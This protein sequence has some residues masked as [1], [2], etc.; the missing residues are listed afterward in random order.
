MDSSSLQAVVGANCRRIREA[1]GVTQAQ[2]ASHARRVGLRWTASKVGD[3]ESGRNDIFARV[4]FAAVLALDT[5][6]GARGPGPL[7]TWHT[8]GM[9]QRNR[10]RVTL[11]DLVGSDGYVTLND[12]FKPAGAKLAAVASG[13]P[14]EFYGGDDAATAGRTEELLSPAPGVLGE[15]YRMSL[16]DVE[17]MRRRSTLTETRLAQR[18]GIEPD[19]LL[20]LSWRLWRP[21]TFSEERDRRA[22]TSVGRRGHVARA[23][24][25][26]LQAELWKEQTRGNR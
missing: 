16:G 6:I 9:T 10:P 13:E 24:T 5:A 17:D 21:R 25:T 23:L 7:T 14:W 19:T 4:L 11:A 15:R 26:Q 8:G 22:G 3:F 18:L 2:L 1:H 12:D 20:G